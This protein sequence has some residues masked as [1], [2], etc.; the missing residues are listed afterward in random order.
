MAI[1]ANGPSRA[2]KGQTFINM[3]LWATSSGRKRKQR[4]R[5]CGCTVVFC[6]LPR[7]LSGSPSSNSRFRTK[8]SF[9]CVQCSYLQSSAATTQVQQRSKDA[10][11]FGYVGR[12]TTISCN[13]GFWFCAVWR[14]VFSVVVAKVTVRCSGAGSR[15]ALVRVAA[16]SWK[17]MYPDLSKWFS[18]RAASI[19]EYLGVAQKIL[20]PK[21]PVSTLLDWHQRQNYPS[22]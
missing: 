16:S 14:D 20:T 22:R 21:L 19:S 15:C 8:P 1:Y 18:D 17:K 10:T 5:Y 2:F 4:H 13:D 12:S 7:R 11:A 3:W 6:F 9:P